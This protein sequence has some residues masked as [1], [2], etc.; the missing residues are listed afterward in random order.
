MQLSIIIVNYNVK[1]YLEQCL[2]SVFSAI[3]ASGL[4]AE[5]FVV[6]NASSD[7]SVAYL[8]EN[9]PKNLFPRL[10][11]IANARNVGFSRANNQAVELAKGKY[12]LFLNPDTVI[13]DTTLSECYAFAEKQH[14]FGAIGVKMLGDNGRFAKESRRGLPTPWVSFCKMTGLTALFPKSRLFARYYMSY[15]NKE[16]TA[17]IEIISGAFMWVSHEVLRKCG[18][19]DED[20]FMYG[21]DI[22]LS[23]RIVQGG[24]KNFYLPLPILHYKGESTQKSSYRYVHVF[25]EAMLIFFRKHYGNLSV[26]FSLPIKCAIIFRAA[27]ALFRQQIGNLYPSKEEDIHFG[28]YGSKENFKQLQQIANKW[29]LNIKFISE[30]HPST[31]KTAEIPSEVTHLIFDTSIYSTDEVFH[32]FEHSDYKH[33]MAFFSPKTGKL[34]TGGQA[35]YL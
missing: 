28:Y 12:I 1:Y 19:F 24:Y 26:L 13:S 31:L 9:F 23:Y 11:I 3:T 34:I 16:Q 4:E 35:Y 29:L 2:H 32:F 6:D 22:D 25:Y 18:S 27:I 17:N 14:Q 20:F 15:L 5:V 21:E 8:H 33:F 30:S 7:N 10:N